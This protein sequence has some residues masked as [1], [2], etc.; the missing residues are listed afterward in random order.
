MLGWNGPLSN[1]YPT[2]LPSIQ[3]APVPV[4]NK[5]FFNCPFLLYYM[6]KWAQILTAA[7]WQCAVQH[8]LQVFSVIFLSS[9]LCRLWKLGIFWWSI[10][11]KSSP[12]NLLNKIKPYLVVNI[13]WWSFKMVSDSSTFYL[14]WPSLLKWI[15]F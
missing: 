2:V 9:D 3:I 13:L 1:L 4:T 8:I 5:I 12:L 14:G 15:F 6:S 11:I 7:T 10:M